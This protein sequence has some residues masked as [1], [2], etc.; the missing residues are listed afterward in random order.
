MV[1]LR[2]QLSI[3]KDVNQQKILR[4]E[5]DQLDKTLTREAAGYESFKKSNDIRWQD[6]YTS[7]EDSDIAI[8]FYNIPKLEH[9][10]IFAITAK[11]QLCAVVLKKDYKTPHVLPLFELDK[12]EDVE[13]SDLY[14][15]DLLYH[16]VWKSLESELVGVK[17]IFFAPDQD[18]YKIGIE[19]ALMPDGKRIDDKYNIYRVSSTRVLAENNNLKNVN[20]AVL[21]GG[22]QYSVE[23]DD[24][25][26]ES[27]Q[28]EHHTRKANR[29]GGVD[30]LRYGVKYLPGTKEEIESIAKQMNET[31]GIKYQ[32]ISGIAGTEEAFRSLENKP[33]NIIHLATHGFYWTEEEAEKRSVATF[34]SKSAYED[35]KYEDQALIRSGL[36]FSGAN[37]SLSGTELPDDVEDGVLTALELSEMNLG[38][39]DLVVLSACQTALGEISGE[40]VFGLQRGFK[41]AGANSLLMSLWKV[42]DEATKILMVEFYK[43]LIHGDSKSMSL[44][45]AQEYLRNQDGF[46]APE[47]W[48]GFILL[49]ALN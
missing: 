39:V 7:L 14:E 25:I 26:E 24:L 29:S 30:E 8:E 23:A 41:L 2:Q 46:G 37:V 15:T 27:R 43:H 19:Y 35:K 10:G 13:Q 9:K 40:G 16:L 22:L 38:E 18:L 3:E 12:L 5:I 6:V 4:K 47:Y 32:A 42:D 31:K 1:V 49:D 11:P 17:N 36:L 34:M 48:A 33:V 45:K 44:K 28:S 20:E 21:F